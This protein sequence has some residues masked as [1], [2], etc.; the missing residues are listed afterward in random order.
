MN[1]KITAMQVAEA[2]R[3]VAA[4]DFLGAKAYIE[5]VY[6]A[7]HTAGP[8]M[9]AQ[10]ALRDVD[11]LRRACERAGVA[12][13]APRKKNPAAW[14][15]RL[16]ALE[17]AM[18]LRTIPRYDQQSAALIRLALDHVPPTDHLWSRPPPMPNTPGAASNSDIVGAL[19]RAGYGHEADA[20]TGRARPRDF[21]PV[22]LAR[23]GIGTRKNPATGTDPSTISTPVLLLL[24]QEARLQQR[25][26]PLVR[27]TRKGLLDWVRIIWGATVPTLLVEEARMVEKRNRAKAKD[28]SP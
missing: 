24:V 17:L 1:A 18:R 22:A 12:V 8:T 6:Q 23:A 16:A 3:R 20:A 5:S 13:P 7:A 10:Q 11:P 28:R 2:A 25:Y 15:G 21:D 4:H 19:R 26:T 27:W 9:W 14:P